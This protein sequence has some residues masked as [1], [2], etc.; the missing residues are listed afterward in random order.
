MLEASARKAD[1]YGVSVSADDGPGQMLV[2]CDEDL[3]SIASD[4]E[5]LLEELSNLRAMTERLLTD[6][7]QQRARAAEYETEALRLKSEHSEALR[8]AAGFEFAL[9]EA[10]ARVNG[11]ETRTANLERELDEMQR[12]LADRER[13][14]SRAQH[15]LEETR[16][17][18]A[19]REDEPSTPSGVSPAVGNAHET[20]AGHVSFGGFPDG[21][22]VTSS[23]ERCPPPGERIEID[24][25]RFVVA[26]VGRSPLPSDERPCAFLL[27]Q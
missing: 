8:R 1:S 4:V 17:Q 6:D 26:R 10:D 15:Q 20:V 7:A 14:L 25:H 18:F 5:A 27:A 23:D 3:S 11:S 12:T 22:R 19:H 9:Q 21:Y 2:R 24:G 13:L 16:T